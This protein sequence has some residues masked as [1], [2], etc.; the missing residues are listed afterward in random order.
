MPKFWTFRAAADEQK[1]AELLLYG[2]ISSTSWWG[3]EV[4]PK[5]F[6]Q[7]LDALG[8]VDLIRV[9]INSDGGD[10]F[11]GQAIHSMLKRHKAQIEVYIDGLAASSASLVAMAGDVVRMPRNAMIMVHNPW[12]LAMGNAEELRK[13][14]DDLDK[15]RE[16]MIAAYEDKTHLDREKIIELLDAETWMTAE[17]AV[18]LG[19]ADEVEQAKEVAASLD[20]S[21]LILNGQRMDLS[22]YRR[23]PKLL[24]SPAKIQQPAAPPAAS[25]PR[26]DI[27]RR[28]LELAEVG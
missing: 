16:G 5:Q 14:A 21:H 22:K 10:L 18:D 4:T 23:P 13:V 1:T 19:F 2:L 25:V 8:D 3:D 11:A 28:R 7:D 26:L 15:A 20:G 6:K 12:V 17:E 27:Y 24:V 9:F